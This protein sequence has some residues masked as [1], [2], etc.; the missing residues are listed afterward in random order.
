MYWIFRSNSQY[1]KCFY[2]SYYEHTTIAEVIVAIGEFVS[3]AKIMNVEKFEIV[4]LT[5]AESKYKNYENA[6]SIQA[7][8]LVASMRFPATSGLLVHR[9]YS[10]KFDEEMKRLLREAKLFFGAQGEIKKFCN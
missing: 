1:M 3:V 5:K 9:G 6:F 4:D 7:E 10:Q 2:T 8:D